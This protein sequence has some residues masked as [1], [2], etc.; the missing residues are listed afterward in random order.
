[1]IDGVH[2]SSFVFHRIDGQVI[3]EFVLL[4]ALLILNAFLAASEVAV[5]EIRKSRLAQLVEAGHTQA[6]VLE[7]LAQDSSR[8]LATLQLGTT[9]AGF[10]AAGTAAV[11]LAPH[12][13]TILARA[14]WPAPS[15]LL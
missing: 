10:L 7:R 8:T 13:A 4:L 12:L 15:S 11:T 5:A 6:K 9:L 3:P 14:T 2:P 1:M